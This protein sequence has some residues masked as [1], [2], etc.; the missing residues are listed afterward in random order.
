MHTREAAERAATAE[1]HWE[2]AKVKPISILSILPDEILSGIVT[3]ISNG[4]KRILS[5][6]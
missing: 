4:S 3:I 1:K 2:N 6:E 5:I